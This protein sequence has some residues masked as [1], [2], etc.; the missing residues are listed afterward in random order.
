MNLAPIP[1]D[2]DRHD[3]QLAE[4]F[5][6]CFGQRCPQ[7]HVSVKAPGLCQA[8]NEKIMEEIERS[9]LRHQDHN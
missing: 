7:C 6:N 9:R 3:R 2:E 4:A 1:F 8:C 5:D